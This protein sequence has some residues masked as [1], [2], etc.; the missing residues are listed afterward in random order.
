LVAI[1]YKLIVEMSLVRVLKEEITF[2]HEETKIAYLFLSGSLSGFW[3]IKTRK[4]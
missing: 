1:E 3:L 2:Y 4:E